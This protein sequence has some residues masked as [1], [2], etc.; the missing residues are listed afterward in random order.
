MKLAT[1]TLTCDSSEIVS[2]F[3]SLEKRVKEV[4][5]VDEAIDFIDSMEEMDYHEFVERVVTL[6][7]KDKSTSEKLLG[8][9]AESVNLMIE[10]YQN[11]QK[12]AR[13]NNRKKKR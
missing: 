1:I 12:V 13:R 10:N 11:D 4:E 9:D 3:S 5:I 8:F 6:L 7:L 2:D